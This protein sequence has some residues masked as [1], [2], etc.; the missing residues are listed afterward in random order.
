MLEE[1]LG[2]YV[3]IGGFVDSRASFNVVA[4]KASTLEKRLQI[5]VYSLREASENK[6]LN[7]LSWIPGSQNIAHGMTKRFVKYNHLLWTF[8]PTNA[9]SIYPSGSINKA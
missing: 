9:I 7:S 5:D 6:E 3:P 1:I 2:T 4:K 8:L